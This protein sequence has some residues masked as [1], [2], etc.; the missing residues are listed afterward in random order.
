MMAEKNAQ[1]TLQYRPTCRREK[2]H[3][4]RNRKS[5]KITQKVRHIII[6]K[7]FFFRG[8]CVKQNAHS[9]YLFLFFLLRI[10]FNFCQFLNFWSFFDAPFLI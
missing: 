6:Y 9:E 7:F 8:K 3:R 5:A 2:H 4:R 10:D 1:I